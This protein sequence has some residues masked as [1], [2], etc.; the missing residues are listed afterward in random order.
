[1]TKL[2]LAAVTVVSC[3][4]GGLASAADSRFDNAFMNPPPKETVYA[5]NHHLGFSW[6]AAMIYW[7]G[8]AAIV[9]EG[10]LRA[11]QREKWWGQDIPILPADVLRTDR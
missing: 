3:L 6:R 7:L 8:G 9:D 2:A 4:G 1:M 5:T 11:S 10:D